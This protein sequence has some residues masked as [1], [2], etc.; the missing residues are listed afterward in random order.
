MSSPSQSVGRS[1]WRS[2]RSS[3]VQRRRPCKR[4]ATMTPLRAHGRSG[5]M[6]QAVDVGGRRG[7]RSPR[8]PQRQTPRVAAASRKPSCRTRTGDPFLTMVVGKVPASSTG[9]QTASTYGERC[10]PGPGSVT[11]RS[12]PS[13]THSVPGRACAL[14]VPDAHGAP[15][16]RETPPMA[17]AVSGPLLATAIAL[18]RP[19]VLRPTR[20]AV[21]RPP[22]QPR[23]ALWAPSGGSARLPAWPRVVSVPPLGLRCSSPRA[24]V[25]R[26]VASRCDRAGMPITCGR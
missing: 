25:A 24:G 7:L 6:G 23:H 26:C 15:G 20:P 17:F 1:A 9:S 22:P 18:R 21:A 12:A 5:V 10:A 16:R 19:G 8:Q 4:R 2:T 3:C 14:G 13:V 11:Q